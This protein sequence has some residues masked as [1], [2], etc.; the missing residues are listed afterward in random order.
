MCS[1]GT[2]A[3]GLSAAAVAAGQAPSYLAQ[4]AFA[5][6]A[7]ILLT[8]QMEVVYGTIRVCMILAAFRWPG[9]GE[10]AAQLPTH[11]FKLPVAA[12]SV[13]ELW[14][15]R[16]HQ[17]LRYYFEGLGSAL[18]HA[19]LP[20]DK[21][22]SAVRASMRCVAAFLMSGLL[23]EYVTWAAFGTVTWRHLTFFLLNGAA[24]LLESWAPAVLAACWQAQGPAGTSSRSSTGACTVTAHV[25]AKVHPVKSGKTSSSSGSDSSSAAKLNGYKMQAL[26]PGWLQHAITL[27]FFILLGPLF[28]EPYRAAA[29]FSERA[30]HPFGQLV[31]PRVLGWMQQGVSQLA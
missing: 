2:G 18:V 8:Q 16:W 31:T 12:G 13:S 27:S 5:L 9:L 17:F 30:F 11:A 7:G 14:G 20:K 4:C 29:F 15:F 23:H 24:A 28:V 21:A 10:L 25:T 22:P 3:A 1:A 6:P 26:L 19:V